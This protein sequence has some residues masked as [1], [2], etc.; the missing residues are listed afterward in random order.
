MEEIITTKEI[1]K[2]IQDNKRT[3]G[4]LLVAVISCIGAGFLL[5]EVIFHLYAIMLLVMMTGLANA[6]RIYYMHLELRIRKG[7][8]NGL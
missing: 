2:R 7:E 8:K 4:W 1:K 6:N 5:T 3:G